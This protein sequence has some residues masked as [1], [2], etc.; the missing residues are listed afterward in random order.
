MIEPLLLLL[1]VFWFILKRSNKGSIINTRMNQKTNKR[2]N[3]GSIINTRM[4]QKINVRS[5]KGSIINTRMNQKT[6]KWSAP[7]ISFLFHPSIYDLA[8]VT[9]LISF[10]VHP[11]IYD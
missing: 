3:K 4:N 5:N 7:L 1:L 8:L 10:L 9:P 11:S 2:S 6:N